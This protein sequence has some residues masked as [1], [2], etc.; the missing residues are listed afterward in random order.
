MNLKVDQL[1]GKKESMNLAILILN[2]DKVNV[3]GNKQN[4]DQ[5]KETNS[6]YPQ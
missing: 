6:K 1:R 4:F 2:T 5:I 3:L